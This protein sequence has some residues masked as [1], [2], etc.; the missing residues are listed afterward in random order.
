MVGAMVNYLTRSSLGVAAPA[1][2][3]DLNITPREYSWITGAFRGAVMLHP[4]CGYV[5]GLKYGFAIL[6]RLGRLSVWHMGRPITGKPSP[7]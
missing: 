6:Q 7:G 1:L 4:F 5:L 3:K 2:L